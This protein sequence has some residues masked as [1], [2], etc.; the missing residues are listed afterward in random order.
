MS[1]TNETKYFSFHFFPKVLKLEQVNSQHVIHLVEGLK[2]LTEFSFVSRPCMAIDNI[3]TMVQA[4]K[5]LQFL[6]MHIDNIKFS[7]DNYDTM[8]KIIKNRHEHLKLH[9]E[10]HSNKVLRIPHTEWRSDLLTI[11]QD[12]NVLTVVEFSV[13]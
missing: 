13:E 9:I 7:Q 1:S 11:R 10:F 2:E 12:Q 5:R 4:A 8:L 6:Y 3:I